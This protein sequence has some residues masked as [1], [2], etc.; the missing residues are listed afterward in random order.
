MA[1]SIGASNHSFHRPNA[2]Q[3]VKPGLSG[4]SRSVDLRDAQEAS[5]PASRNMRG[6]RDARQSSFFVWPSTKTLLGALGFMALG[7]VAGLI[8]AA[9]T[10]APFTL[11]V[12]G[13]ALGLLIFGGIKL[14]A[15][16]RRTGA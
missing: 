16:A 9:A 11:A 7:V 12:G 6:V 2:V 3:P 13:A 15:N 4:V 5:A 14:E 8:V 1:C 10:T